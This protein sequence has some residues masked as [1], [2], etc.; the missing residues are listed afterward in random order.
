M[1]AVSFERIH[2][3][4]LI[5]M[6]IIPLQFINGQNADNLDLTG[7]ERYTIYLPSDAKPGQIIQVKVNNHSNFNL[8][9]F[10][11]RRWKII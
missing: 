5:G 8:L 2:R 11:D 6:G 7:K 9:Y 1:I 10:L 4:N 3:S